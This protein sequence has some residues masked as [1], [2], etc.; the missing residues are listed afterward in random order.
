MA[1]IVFLDI[2]GVLLPFGDSVSA[3]EPPAL[4][5]DTCLGALS[6]LLAAPLPGGATPEVVL[7]S[8][9]RARPAFIKDILS[10][11][12]R[13]G[14]AHHSSPLATLGIADRFFDTTSVNQFGPRQH[15]I[16]VWLE[17]RRARGEAAPAAWVC[18]D[19]E[20]LLDGK[21][22]ASRRGQ[23]EGHVVQTPS[24]VGLTPSLA[25]K[26]VEL[27][28]TQLELG[29]PTEI[30]RSAPKRPRGDEA[31]EGMPC[32]VVGCIRC[33]RDCYTGGDGDT[34]RGD[35]LPE[36]RARFGCPKA[37][38]GECDMVICTECAV[39]NWPLAAHAVAPHTCRDHDKECVDLQRSG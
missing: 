3:V 9:W 30:E 37:L 12:R 11:F 22:C 39:A 17:R 10:E 14:A 13:Y 8:T 38:S 21:A 24:D 25:D 6:R 4:F 28:R 15:E 18:L 1:T 35:E 36:L 5:P 31:N 32:L 34:S 16:A 26:G 19:D 20:E 29:E 27:L 2:D 23:F 7:S 33:D